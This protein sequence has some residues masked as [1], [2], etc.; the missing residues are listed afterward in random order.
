MLQGRRH[1]RHSGGASLAMSAT[2]DPQQAGSL[3]SECSGGLSCR[4]AK[5]G[6]LDMEGNAFSVACR[7]SGLT[8]NGSSGSMVVLEQ[9]FHSQTW[10]ANT[11]MQMRP[12]E[13][14]PS[15]PSRSPTPNQPHKVSTCLHPFS[16]R[17]LLLPKPSGD[18][19]AFIRASSSRQAREPADAQGCFGSLGLWAELADLS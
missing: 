4:T 13:R 1:R 14:A 5:R 18:S 11:S 16:P 3:E 2:L 19:K 10:K 7:A 8:K 17:P 15:L 12:A 6:L 9:N